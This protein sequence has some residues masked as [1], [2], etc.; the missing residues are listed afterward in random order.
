MVTENERLSS[1]WVHYGVLDRLKARAGWPESKELPANFSGSLRKLAGV[2]GLSVDDVVE[3]FCFSHI[4]DIADNFEVDISL[5]P[6]KATDELKQKKPVSAWRSEL[7][8][9]IAPG[10]WRDLKR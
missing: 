2:M 3:E 7:A 4:P 6:A 8:R 5:P 1:G 10:V 9:G